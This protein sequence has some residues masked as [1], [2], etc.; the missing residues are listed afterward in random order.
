MKR[1]IRLTESD[2]VR[3]VKRV[4]K[5][6]SILSGG[7]NPMF[8]ISKGTGEFSG[9]TPRSET[10]NSVV[11]FDHPIR[12]KSKDWVRETFVKAHKLHGKSD[13]DS[14]YI[15]KRLHADIDGLG[16]GEILKTLN[17][18]KT[19]NQL[20]SVITSYNELYKLSL[21]VDIESEWSTSWDSLWLSIKRLNPNVELF[22]PMGGMDS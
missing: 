13:S 2:L 18:I 1:I 12:A 17:T 9:K 20:S 7:N 6:Q 19:I 16:S 10:D 15:A 4:I 14:N 22:L 5:E 8:N 11:D 21:Y 3:L